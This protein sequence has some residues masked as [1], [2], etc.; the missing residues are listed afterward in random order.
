[1]IHLLCHSSGLGNIS[2]LI[3]N[4]KVQSTQKPNLPEYQNIKFLE[5]G[6]C[7]FVI[8]HIHANCGYIVTSQS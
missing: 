8:R 7:N 4:A 3:Y 5:F 1:M 2:G 6:I